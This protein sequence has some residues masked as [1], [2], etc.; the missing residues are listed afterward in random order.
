MSETP[1]RTRSGYHVGIFTVDPDAY[2]NLLALYHLLQWGVEE[3]LN[4]KKIDENNHCENSENFLKHIHTFT[5][6][7][8][9]RLV[10]RHSQDASAAVGDRHSVS[11]RNTGYESLLISSA[12]KRII[13]V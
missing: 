7:D 5:L 13:C 12:H 6:Y 8:L 10:K 3:F 9:E 2:S 1:H 11:S 4:E